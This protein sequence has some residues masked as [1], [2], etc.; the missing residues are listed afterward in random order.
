MSEREHGCVTYFDHGNDRFVIWRHDERFELSSAC[1]GLHEWTYNT[2]FQS[3]AREVHQLACEVGR[4]KRAEI[5][6]E[7]NR[8]KALEYLEA[9]ASQCTPL[10][11]WQLRA[12]AGDIR[13]GMHLTDSVRIH[14]APY[15]VVASETESQREI[16]HILHQALPGE[17]YGCAR[18]PDDAVNARVELRYSRP[19]PVNTVGDPVNAEPDSVNDGRGVTPEEERRRGEEHEAEQRDLA[20]QKLAELEEENRRLL[21]LLCAVKQAALAL[22]PGGAE[23]G[24]RNDVLWLIQRGDGIVAADMR[25]LH[26]LQRVQPPKPEADDL[27]GFVVW[28]RHDGD[29]VKLVGVSEAEELVPGA[30][31]NVSYEPF[32]EEVS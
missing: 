6:A 18:V 2:L 8:R 5:E 26:P 12:A 29:I 1:I 3:M 25:S 23:D 4:L 17:I 24:L 20:S 28:H 13:E 21:G 7:R 16:A 9:Y 19:V 22:P 15:E 10:L 32:L 27:R 14:V 11:A 30:T 31:V